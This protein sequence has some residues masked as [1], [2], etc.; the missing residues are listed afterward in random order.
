MSFFL[1]EK[2]KRKFSAS[3]CWSYVKGDLFQGQAKRIKCSKNNRL[4]S[5]KIFVTMYI[6]RKKSIYITNWSNIST[7]LMKTFKNWNWNNWNNMISTIN[8][9]ICIIYLHRNWQIT[10]MLIV[11]LCFLSMEY[12]PL[13]YFHLQTSFYNCSYL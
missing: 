12:F 11:C 1:S 9:F 7:Y 8:F 2:N 3:G 4:R 5:R 13:K 10:L 6:K